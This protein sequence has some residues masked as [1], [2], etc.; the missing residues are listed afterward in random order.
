MVLVEAP[1]HASIGTF[2]RHVGDRHGFVHVLTDMQELLQLSVGALVVLCPCPGDAEWLNIKRPWIVERS[3]RVLIWAD[4]EL[5]GT[6]HENAPDF[7][8]WISHHQPCPPTPVSFAVAGLGAAEV[9]PGLCWPAAPESF[10]AL[11]RQTDP[12][13]QSVHISAALPYQEMVDRITAARDAWIVW[14]SVDGPSRARRVRWALAECGRSGRTALCGRQPLTPGW[15][16]LHADRVALHELTSRLAAAMTPSPARIAALCDLEPEAA[17]L[18]PELSRAGHTLAEL[19]DR[20]MRADPGAALGE[21]SLMLADDIF[22]AIELPPIRRAWSHHPQ[23]S[24]LLADESREVQ[25]QLLAGHVVEPEVVARVAAIAAWQGPLPAPPSSPLLRGWQTEAL[26]RGGRTSAADWLEFTDVAERLA[27]HDVQIAWAIRGMRSEPAVDEETAS[28]LMMQMFEALEHLDNAEVSERILSTTLRAIVT[29]LAGGVIVALRYAEVLSQRGKL[30]SAADL[31]AGA[32]GRVKASEASITPE[33]HHTLLEQLIDVLDE[34]GEPDASV[35]QRRLDELER[36]N[37]DIQT[38][39]ATIEA[40]P[41]PSE[42]MTLTQLEQGLGADHPRVIRARIELAEQLASDGRLEESR[43]MLDAATRMYEAN[44]LQ[45][46]HLV[47]ELAL[48]RIAAHHRANEFDEAEQ[49]FRGVTTFF[50][51]TIGLEHPAWCELAE[52]YAEQLVSADMPEAAEGVLRELI[53]A[54]RDAHG[55]SSE[56]HR[57]AVV[58]LA[59]VLCEAG[60]WNEAEQCLTDLVPDLLRADIKD[61]QLFAQ[62]DHMR[63]DIHQARG[64]FEAAEEILRALLVRLTAEPQADPGTL[65]GTFTELGE[66]LMGEARYADALKLY[67]DAQTH[68]PDAAKTWTAAIRRARQALRSQAE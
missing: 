50:I 6:I 2:I 48:A 45:D 26:I 49:L 43:A 44:V 51:E 33:V 54:A 28:A 32:L 14:S 59:D 64:E 21:L 38:G 35:Y 12:S 52:D 30:R 5:A 39:L 60:R 8:D 62:I 67:T 56:L 10:E 53:Q 66:L 29:D 25:H 41:S 34:L 31:L 9:E 19:D 58:E 1:D 27:N 4:R 15:A 61:P 11:L 24:Q 17:M 7:F 65:T 20:L 16:P 57:E 37:P 55:P 13:A 63:A 42:Q 68:L 23:R 46:P 40:D 18:I 22:S 3:L 47:A 36:L